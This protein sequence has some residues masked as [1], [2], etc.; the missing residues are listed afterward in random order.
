MLFDYFLKTG[1]HACAIILVKDLTMMLFFL[2]F[3]LMFPFLVLFFVFKT[4]G[5]YYS[6]YPG[7]S[8]TVRGS[9]FCCGS[10]LLLCF[11]L[12]P[13]VTKR[14]RNFYFLDRECIFKPVK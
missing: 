3:S 11:I 7:P 13:F 9:N 5:I 12:C 4:C 10:F 6:V 14:G 1:I 8:E 2:Q